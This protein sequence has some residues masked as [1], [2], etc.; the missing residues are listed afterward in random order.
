MPIKWKTDQ[1]NVFNDRTF[2]KFLFK[3]ILKEIYTNVCPLQFIYITA[4]E[5]ETELNRKTEL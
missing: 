3:F 4:F 5:V 2:E 1:E